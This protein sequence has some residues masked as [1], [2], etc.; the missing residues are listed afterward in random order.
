VTSPTGKGLGALREVVQLVWSE[1]SRFVRVRLIAVLSLVITASVLTALGPIALKLV[2]DAFTGQAHGSSASPVLLLGAFVLAQFLARTADEIRGLI[3]ARVERR[4]FRALSERLFAHLMQLP[5]RLHLQR[6]TGAVGQ[7]LEQGLQG[8][9]MILYHLVFT[10]LPVTAQLG[11]VVLVLAGLARPVFLGI[12]CAAVACYGMVFAYGAARVSRAARAASAAHVAAHAAITDSVLNYETVKYFT[13]E[14]VVQARVGEAL[15]RTEAEWAGFYR[16]YTWSGLRAATV[17]SIFLAAAVLCA[18][19]EVEAGRMTVGDFVLINT[20]MLQI[21]GPVEML[22]YAMQAFSQG[23]A[24]MERMMALLRETPEPK[25]RCDLALL[26]GPGTLEFQEVSLCYRPGHA[27]LTGV[28]FDVP[29]GR[30]LGVVGASGSGKST[31]VRLLVRLLEPDS[32][33]VLLDGVPISEMPLATLRQAIAVVPQDTVLFDDTIAY[34]IGFGRSGASRQEVE[35]AAMLAHLHE[36]IMSLPDGYETRVGERGVRLSGGER[37][38]ISIARAALKRP[39]VFVFDE[40]TSS[41][42][43]H[44]EREIL[45]NLREIARATTTLVIAHRLST[46]ADAH[47]IAV[48]DSGT[49]V[50][51]GTHEELLVLGGHYA[52]LWAA[53]KQGASPQAT[54]GLTA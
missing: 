16:R 11:S 8:Y 40:A 34:N 22:G 21:I 3:H 6:Q 31:L 17:F 36:F 12:F 29:G 25:S 30:T 1:A 44:T 14:S 52:A 5:L 37:Q 35:R 23:V 48:L 45:A 7:T 43:T 51:R 20:Y 19:R 10:L 50:E 54:Q 26:G 47:E 4:M 18:A 41:L 32:G 9:R 24:M 13:A 39:R 46:V 27:V 53:Q 33:R 15:S 38:R 42:D 2:I 28:S 49:V